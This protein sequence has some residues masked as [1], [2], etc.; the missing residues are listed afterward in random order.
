M[1]DFL[2]HCLE[3][4]KPPPLGA[5]E[6]LAFVDDNPFVVSS[7]SESS[8]SNGPSKN[9]IVEAP[10]VDTHIVVVEESLGQQ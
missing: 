3:N 9:P 6:S 2:T 7:P 1:E 5:L 4:L 8:M 10:K